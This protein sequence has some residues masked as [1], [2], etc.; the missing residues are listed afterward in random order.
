MTMKMSVRMS[1]TVTDILVRYVEKGAEDYMCIISCTEV[2][3]RPM[4]HN[5][6]LRCAAIVITQRTIN[7]EAFS[8]KAKQST[9]SIGITAPHGRG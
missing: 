5:I 1:S 8:I 9:T 4:I 6:W 2:M 3:E 7:R